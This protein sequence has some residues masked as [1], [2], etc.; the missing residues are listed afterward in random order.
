LLPQRGNE[1]KAGGRKADDLSSV[2]LG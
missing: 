2:Q 1:L